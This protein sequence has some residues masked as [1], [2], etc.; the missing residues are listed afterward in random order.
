MVDRKLLYKLDSIER[1]EFL[2]ITE[3]AESLPQDQIED[4][5]KSI[6]KELTIYDI[7]EN[8]R[9]KSIIEIWLSEG[10]RIKLNPNNSKKI[11]RYAYLNEKKNQLIMELF[12]RFDREELKESYPN[13]HERFKKEFNL[14]FESIVENTEIQDIVISYKIYLKHLFYTILNNLIIGHEKSLANSNIFKSK[15]SKNKTS[16]FADIFDLFT[17]TDIIQLIL[18]DNNEKI[19]LISDE[20]KKRVNAFSGRKLKGDA[21]MKYEE[22]INIQEEMLSRKYRNSKEKRD[23]T[24]LAYAVRAYYTRNSL[25]LTKPE[26]LKVSNNIYK[27]QSKGKL[28]K[29]DRKN[30]SK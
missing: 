20:Y 15:R 18:T 5:I 17:I 11:K 21:K 24:S 19:K 10:E 14:F 25:D 16:M 13:L 7:F 30:T 8:P 22:I 28:R 3:Y 12:Y 26:F 6:N 27:L 9:I 1:K 2:R 29:L 23:S 4:K